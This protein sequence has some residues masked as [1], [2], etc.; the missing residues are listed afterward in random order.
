MVSKAVD[1]GVEHG[2]DDGVEDGHHLVEAD[3]RGRSGADVH[4]EES[5]VEEAHHG[6]V[7]RAGGNTTFKCLHLVI[8]CSLNILIVQQVVWISVS[9]M[10][11]S[12]LSISKP[13]P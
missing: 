7:G 13:L 4:E 8:K 12:S 5:A 11:H 3:G 1:E 9:K 10:S 2:R 6:Q